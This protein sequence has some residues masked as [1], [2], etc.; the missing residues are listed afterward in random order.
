MTRAPKV[1]VGLLLC[2][3]E[4]EPEDIVAAIDLRPTK[5]WREGDSI[6]RTNIRRKST[7]WKFQIAERET[8]D[9]NSLICELLD[10]VE[11]FA[12]QIAIARKRF[13]LESELY[14]SVFVL[15]ATPSL[16]FPS[17][18][19]RRLSELEVDLDIDIIGMNPSS[20]V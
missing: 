2:G 5:V 11:P 13:K 19:I 15:E 4:V 7:V 9:V 10:V 14:A 16:S 3:H 20:D 17:A 8:F 12:E 18:T 6:E 1:T